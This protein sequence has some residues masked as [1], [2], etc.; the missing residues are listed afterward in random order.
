[1]IILFIQLFI[2]FN[3]GFSFNEVGYTTSIYSNNKLYVYEPNDIELK[4]SGL[5][6]Y[7]LKDGPMS[8]IKPQLVN[9]TNSNPIYTPQFLQFPDSLANWRS[10]EIWMTGGISVPKLEDNTISKENWSCEIIN[11]SELKFHDDF[12]PMPP[13]ENFPNS[14]FSQTIVNGDNGLELYIIG[15]LVYS[16]ELDKELITNYFYKYEFN[17]G[18]WVD[19]NKATESI[20]QPRAFHKVIKVDNSL[21][22]I[23]GIQNNKNL[24]KKFEHTVPVNDETDESDINIIFKFDLIEQKW[25]IVEAKLNKDPSVYKSV[26]ATGAAYELYRGKIISY[27]ILYNYVENKYEPQI[28][29]LDYNNWEWQWHDVKT[30]IGIGNSLLLSYYQTLIISNQLILIHGKLEYIIKSLNF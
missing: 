10:H 25:S 15:G 6:I 21:L 8:E 28:G 5:T 30:E 2:S 23:G 24:K 19:L 13:F 12:I 26:K 20:L 16:K 18:K 4:W 11:D 17:T 9:I 14:G 7:D 22:L 27:V 1:M 3:F 29:I